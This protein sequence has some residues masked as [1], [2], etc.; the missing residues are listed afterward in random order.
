MDIDR[1]GTQM[2]SQSVQPAESLRERPHAARLRDEILRI[3]IRR[4]PPKS[5]WQPQSDDVGG[6]QRPRA[7][8]PLRAPD[9]ESAPGS[10]PPPVPWNGRSVAGPQ[11]IRQRPAYADGRMP[12]VHS[13]VCWRTRRMPPARA[14]PEQVECLLRQPLPD[15]A[16]VEDTHLHR[17][18][19]VQPLPHFRACFIVGVEIEVE[20]LFRHC[21]LPSAVRYWAWIEPHREWR[22]HRVC[23]PRAREATPE[24]GAPSAPRPGVPSCRFRPGR[25]RTGRIDLVDP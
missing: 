5:A 20:T 9:R 2:T 1:T 16:G 13:W 3:D 4:P 25:H 6:R 21:R 7:W 8:M 19:R 10:A 18:H 11:P 17:L 12:P 24:G 15:V 23:T 14:P 22:V